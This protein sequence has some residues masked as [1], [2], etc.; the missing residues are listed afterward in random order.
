MIQEEVCEVA[1]F[2]RRFLTNVTGWLGTISRA[3]SQL[4]SALFEPAGEPFFCADALLVCF[5]DVVVFEGFELCASAAGEAIKIAARLKAI[6]NETVDP[7]FFA[8][9]EAPVNSSFF[10][11]KQF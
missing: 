2:G 10:A 3:P 6:A 1:G 8:I 9:M 7:A 4:D 11:T 5:P